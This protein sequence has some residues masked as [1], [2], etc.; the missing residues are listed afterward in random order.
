VQPRAG[1]WLAVIAVAVVAAVVT[2][3]LT[4]AVVERRGDAPTPAPVPAMIPSLAPAPTTAPSP[5]PWGKALVDNMTRM[6]EQAD[7]RRERE[8]AYELCKLREQAGE[9]LVCTRPF[10]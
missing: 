2:V 1:F 4:L 3:F 8:Q 9:S 7:E 6:A 10:P 5:A